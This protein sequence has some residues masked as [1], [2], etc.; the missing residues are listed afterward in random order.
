MFDRALSAL[1]WLAF[2]CTG[3]A[4]GLISAALVHA[5][6]SVGGTPISQGVLVAGLANAAS[7]W[8]AARFFRPGAW[9][10]GLGWFLAA[11]VL[12]FGGPGGDVL[13]AGDNATAVFW[14]VGTV[15]AVAG[16]QGGL[17][18]FSP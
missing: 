13:L 16:V 2:A 12:S 11:G 9:A 18:T 1:T 7:G 6:W 8:L 3:V 4:L 10:P 14:V 17:R 5:D 15:C